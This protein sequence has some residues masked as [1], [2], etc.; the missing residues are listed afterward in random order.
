MMIDDL[1][2]YR[3]YAADMKHPSDVAVDYIYEFFS[4]TYFN[5]DTRREAVEY[6]RQYKA[7]LHR[8]IL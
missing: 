5:V 1:R 7:S 4:H 2:D 3:F 6:R 8:P